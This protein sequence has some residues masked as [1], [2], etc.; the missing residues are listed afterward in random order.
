MNW[1]LK[2]SLWEIV[3]YYHLEE[4]WLAYS[5]EGVELDQSFDHE[6]GT[7]EKHRDPAEYADEHR[8]DNIVGFFQS[9][10]MAGHWVQTVLKNCQ[11]PGKVLEIDEATAKTVINY[12][13]EFEV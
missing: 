3:K 6:F 7:K 12:K 13:F 9:S 8:E 4:E 11:V 10:V 2:D 5:V 1:T